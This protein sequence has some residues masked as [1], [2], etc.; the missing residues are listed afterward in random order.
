M[1]TTATSAATPGGASQTSSVSVQ[2]GQVSVRGPAVTTPCH[3]PKSVPVMVTV[4][5]GGGTAGSREGYT[6]VT[7]GARYLHTPR[8][9]KTTTPSTSTATWYVRPAA[10][11]AGGATHLASNEQTRK[12]RT[13]LAFTE[14]HSTGVPHDCQPTCQHIPN[15]VVTTGHV[16]HTPPGALLALTSETSRAVALHKCH[17]GVV[18]QLGASYGDDGPACHGSGK[19]HHVAHHM[20]RG[21]G[22]VRVSIRHWRWNTCRRHYH[23]TCPLS[24][25]QKLQIILGYS[26]RGGL[27]RQVQATQ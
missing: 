9:N 11:P 1:T 7:P 27:I 5:P 17:G 19:R 20:A 4:V 12:A 13:V 23:V 3:L 21:R 25:K 2:D 8:S 6:A 18:A 26:L 14:W 16:R 10:E 22:L 15:L 24:S